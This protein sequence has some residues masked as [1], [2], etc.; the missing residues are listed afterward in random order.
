[1]ESSITIRIYASDWKKLRRIFPGMKGESLAMYLRR[2]VEA[3]RNG[4]NQ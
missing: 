3:I 4:N 1:M 2:Y